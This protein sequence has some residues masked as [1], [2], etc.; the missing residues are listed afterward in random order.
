MDNSEVAIFGMGCFWCTEAIFKSL[1]GVKSVEPGYAGGDIDYPNEFDVHAGYTGHAEVTRIQF[2]PNEITYKDLL[3][4]FWNLHNPTS[5]NRQG[6]D[7][8]T[9]YRSIILYTSDKQKEEA[10]ESKKALTESKQYESPIVTAILPLEKF[11]DAEEYHRD[12]YDRHKDDPYCEIIISP[13]LKHL[14]EKFGAKLKEI[15][16]G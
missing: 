9:E 5:L 14:R 15:S 1:K 10:E 12:Y 16:E 7:V 8:G 4:V 11:F 6:N 2:D 13:K 3:E